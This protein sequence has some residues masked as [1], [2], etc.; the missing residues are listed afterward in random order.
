M[1]SRQ[2][3]SA[4]RVPRSYRSPSSPSLLLRV[5]KENPHVAGLGRCGRRPRR[6]TY[7]PMEEPSTTSGADLRRRSAPGSGHIPNIAVM[8][9]GSRCSKVVVS[10]LR[11]N[12]RARLQEAFSSSDVVRRAI[13]A[14]F[15]PVLCAAGVAKVVGVELRHHIDRRR[16]RV[17][18]NPVEHRIRA[19]FDMIGH[20]QMPNTEVLAPT[21]IRKYSNAVRR[22]CSPI[23]EGGL[24]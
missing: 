15:V 9:N 24:N 7:V 4:A 20:D 11:P 1:D 21:S 19:A 10:N 17:L 6:S 18:G 5:G 8:L 3:V 23:C 14:V 12:S 13:S 2:H 22:S 16:R